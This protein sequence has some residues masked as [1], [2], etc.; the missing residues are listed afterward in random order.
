[1]GI[2]ELGLPDVMR[3]IGFRVR[4]ENGIHRLAK[5]ALCEAQILSGVELSV[6]E[7]GF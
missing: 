7:S 1:M 6:W 4:V 3:I 2:A 5:M